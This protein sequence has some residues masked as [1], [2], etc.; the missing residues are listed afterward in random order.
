LTVLYYC[1]APGFI[2]HLLKPF[3]DDSHMLN[4]YQA[5]DG[6]PKIAVQFSF[7]VK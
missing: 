5:A 3:E 4:F 1:K 7:K 2:Y 6:L